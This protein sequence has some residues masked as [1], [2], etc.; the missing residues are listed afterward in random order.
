MTAKNRSA[1]TAIPLGPADVAISGAAKRHL[2]NTIA[3]IVND[4][5]PAGM[6]VVNVPVGQANAIKSSFEDVGWK[7]EIAKCNGMLAELRF[8][9]S[10]DPHLTAEPSPIALLA[11]VRGEIVE[12]LKQIP[13]IKG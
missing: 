4:I 7:V 10:D 6:R 8:A 1:T 9:S 5:L 3:Q 13:P 11:Q 2:A 12:L